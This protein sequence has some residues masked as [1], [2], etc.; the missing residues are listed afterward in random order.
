MKALGQ[1][2]GLEKG[3]FTTVANHLIQQ[4][5]VVSQKDPKDKRITI[6]TLTPKGA[7]KAKELD[8][9]LNNHLEAKLS[10]LDS[11]ERE[12]LQQLLDHLQRINSK[13][14]QGA[15]CER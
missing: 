3:S 6:L 15:T 11:E 7:E 13:L 14:N 1:K 2:V 5:Y 12:G 9:F 10:P 8:A 4:G